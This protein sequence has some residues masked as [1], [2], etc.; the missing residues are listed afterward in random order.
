MK[1]LIILSLL[2]T[3]CSMNVEETVIEGKANKVKEEAKTKQET[4]T[5]VKAKM[6]IKT[7]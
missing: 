5:K 1:I 7:L 3:A 2:C 6:P 4:K